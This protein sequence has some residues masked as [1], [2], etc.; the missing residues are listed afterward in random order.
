MALD[1]VATGVR[2]WNGKHYC[3]IYHWF[4]GTTTVFKHL[5]LWLQ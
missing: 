1:F 4:W 3:I 2:S 5:N